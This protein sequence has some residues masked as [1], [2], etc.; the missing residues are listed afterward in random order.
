VD[1]QSHWSLTA[2][3][4]RIKRKLSPINTSIKKMTKEKRKG[5]FEK[6]IERKSVRGVAVETHTAPP[7]LSHTL[8]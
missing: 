7:L 4:L 6:D 2:W 3:A 8:A 1:Q 5:L